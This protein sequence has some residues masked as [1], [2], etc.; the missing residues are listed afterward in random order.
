MKK[1]ILYLQHNP[2][3]PQQLTFDF[4]Y[5]AK[6]GAE[7]FDIKVKTFEDSSEVPGEPTNI[8]IGSVEQLSKWLKDN[9][10]TIPQAID[11]HLF[12]EFLGRQIATM[13][14]VEFV[15]MAIDVYEADR[16]SYIPQFIK[17]ASD[18]KAF[19]GYVVDDPRMIPLWSNNYAGTIVV[20]DVVDIVSEYRVYI[21]N[22][23]IL[24]MKHYQGDYFKYPN[25]EIIHACKEIGDKLNYHS[26]VLDFGVLS[27]G[28]TILIEPNDAFA[29][30]DY[31]LEPEKYYL[32]VRNRWLQMTGIRKSM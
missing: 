16:Y 8:L 11:L 5:S 18:I 32:M 17:P 25:P 14:M 21:T 27:D 23:Q 31:G 10:Y 30:G 6:M 22:N 29:I 24:G 19:T 9:E 2:N 15:D 20:Q 28:S 26:Y 12:S 1:P 7:Y 13:E 4:C 3:K